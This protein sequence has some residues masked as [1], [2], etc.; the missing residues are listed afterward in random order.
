MV[1]NSLRQ[2]SFLRKGLG[3]GVR[4]PLRGKSEDWAAGAHQHAGLPQGLTGAG[5]G[6][7]VALRIRRTSGFSDPPQLLLLRS[8][9]RL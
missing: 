9:N 5:D 3:T 7:R 6:I 1:P 8:R 4:G 2:H